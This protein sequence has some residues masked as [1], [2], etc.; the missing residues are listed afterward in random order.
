ML[1]FDDNPADV[2]LVASALEAAGIRVLRA[3]GGQEG[4]RIAMENKPA[5]I[6]LDILMPDLS[7][8]EVIERLRANEET[9]NIPIIVLTVKDLTE[10]E[11]KMLNRQAATIMMKA[12]FKRGGFLSEVKSILSPSRK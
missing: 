4:I 2:K 11:Y 3:Y 9:Q 7:G 10:E 12:G 1:W 6:V 5:L 8:F